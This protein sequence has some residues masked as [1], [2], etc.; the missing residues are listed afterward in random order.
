[1]REFA[2]IQPPWNDIEVERSVDQAIASGRTRIRKSSM[3]IGP[4]NGFTR[5][6]RLIADRKI[7][8]AIELGLIPPATKCS[9]CPSEEGRIDYHA[10]DYSRPL[11]VAPICMKCHMALHNRNRSEGYARSWQKLVAA[12]GDG[13]RWFE[14]LWQSPP[15]S[16]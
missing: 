4:Y 3:R 12:H 13:T 5:E 11:I 8:V 15:E 14:Y 1:M 10:E 2:P 7:K 9:I 6:A 16:E